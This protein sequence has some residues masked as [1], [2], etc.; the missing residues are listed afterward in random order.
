MCAKFSK[1]V[2][3]GGLAELRSK[4]ASL[5]LI[6]QTHPFVPTCLPVKRRAQPWSR[7]AAGH[8]RRRRGLDGGEHGAKLN[9]SGLGRTS[10]CFL[11]V[12]AQII[13]VE[14]AMLLEPILMRLDGE[15]P[16]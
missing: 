12:F 7:L 8:R 5:C 15:R 11:F 3:G 13:H 10:Q 16:H 6:G 14:V 2:M 1:S 4:L 9:R